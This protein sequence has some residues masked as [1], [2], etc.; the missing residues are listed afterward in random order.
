M[1]SYTLK[2]PQSLHEWVSQAEN[3]YYGWP[4]NAKVPPNSDTKA[5]NFMRCLSERARA[6]TCDMSQWLALIKYEC[7]LFS[8]CK[9][10]GEWEKKGRNG[11]ELY[12][13]IAP[14]EFSVKNKRMHLFD[15][16]VKRMTHT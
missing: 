13:A 6:R 9:L 1:V 4:S 16:K 12:G 3:T 11:S 5:L 10:K 8:V 15:W 14:N 2:H 7:V